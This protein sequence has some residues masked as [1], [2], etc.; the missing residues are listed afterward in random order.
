MTEVEQIAVNGCDF[1]LD[2]NFAECCDAH[3]VA[4]ANGSSF[5]EF[6][7]S[8]I[9]LYHCVSFQTGYLMAAI[10]LIG[11]T[12]GGAFVWKWSFLGKRSVYE[13]IFKRKY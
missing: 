12:I 8:G 3:D 10:M 13:L 9:D 4:Y 5:K 6:I 7:N 2:G 1:W 11:V